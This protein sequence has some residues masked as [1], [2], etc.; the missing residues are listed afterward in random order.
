MS[1]ETSSIDYSVI[2]PVFNG[3]DNLK[4]LND[5]LINFFRSNNYSFEIIYVDDYSIDDSWDILEKLYENNSSVVKIIRFAKNFGQ[6]KATICG[7]EY[8]KGSFVITIDDDLEKAP[9]DIK[10][11]IES[12]SISKADLTYGM[13]PDDK[14][15]TIRKILTR[16]Y[17]FLSKAEGKEKGKGSSFRLLTR[18]LANKIIPHSNS[19]LFLDE[20]FLWYIPKGEYVRLESV[21]ERKRSRYSLLKLIK[22]TFH[23]ILY[24][25]TIPLQ[26]FI[27]FGFSLALVNFLIGM[28]YLFKKIFFSSELGFTSVIV[29]ILFTTG[30]ILLGMGILG[31]YISRIYNLL[32]NA[33][34]YNIAEKKC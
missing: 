14:T 13:Y 29:S 27:F 17:K 5:R 24:T 12:Q 25:T 9:E 10:F 26:L 7:I 18:D 2:V 33:P 21:G 1:L 8:S 34:P 22:L 19:F 6:H 16:F 31:I 28:F 11:L 3:A 4:Q 15:Q 30:I 20:I 32:N 23:V